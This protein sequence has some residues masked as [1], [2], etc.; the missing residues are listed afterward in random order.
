MNL[1]LD[2]AL[3]AH[4]SEPP[5]HYAA[6]TSAEAD[7]TLHSVEVRVTW[8]NDNPNTIANRL[9]AR[10]QREPTSAELASEVRRIL[11]RES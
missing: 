6:R 7:D 3:A 2:A 5:A 9:A 11:S 1:S 8:R 10:L 4:R